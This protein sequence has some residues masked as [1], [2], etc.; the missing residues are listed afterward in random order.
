MHEIQ[1]SDIM[2]D[3][4]LG[5]VELPEHEQTCIKQRKEHSFKICCTTTRTSTLLIRRDAKTNK[6]RKKAVELR[7][8]QLHFGLSLHSKVGYTAWVLN[9][10]FTRAR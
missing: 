8:V 10:A 7:Q 1:V 3:S 4:I 6:L 5:F 9:P 2:I